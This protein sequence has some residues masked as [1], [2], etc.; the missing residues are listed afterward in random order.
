MNGDHADRLMEQAL[1]HFRHGNVPAAIETLR[2]CLSLD[3]DWAMAHAL[4]ATCL[5]NQKRL[6]AAGHEAMLALAADPTEPFAHMAAA[7]VAFGKREFRTAWRHLEEVLA[8]NPEH[9]EA[10]LLLAEIARATRRHQEILPILETAL[11]YEPDNPEVLAAL[12][13]HHR[14]NGNR[15]AADALARQALGLNAQSVSALVLMGRLALDRGDIQDA[16]SHAVSALCQDPND[17]GA[18][19][20]LVAVKT[21]QSLLFGLWWRYHSWLEKMGT[22]RAILVLLLAFVGYRIG[23]VYATETDAPFLALGMSLVWIGFAIYTWVGPAIFN[24]QLKKELETVQLAQ[25]F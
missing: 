1:I 5:Y 2:H 15:E 10:Y 18:L 8:A 24:K 6:H 9:V 11:G 25:T 21:R 20:L 13:E 7:L 17:I 12:G 16:R 23:T 19:Y 4:L 14:G 22:T 3:P